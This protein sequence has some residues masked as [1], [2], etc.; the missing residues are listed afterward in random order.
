MQMTILRADEKDEGHQSQRSTI[1][2]AS[3]KFA[4]SNFGQLWRD[5]LNFETYHPITSLLRKALSL[6]SI[7]EHNAETP[8]RLV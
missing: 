7:T 3:T 8:R 5:Q 2:N 6:A 4:S 1:A